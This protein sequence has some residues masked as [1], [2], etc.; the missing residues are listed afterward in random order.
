MPLTRVPDKA[1]PPEPSEPSAASPG[2]HAL[3]LEGVSKSFGDIRANED[4]TLRVRRGAI[5][6]IV[7]ENGAGKT[8]LMRIAYGFYQADAG[9][10]FVDD[11]PVDLTSPRVA[12]GSGIAMVHQ[13]SLLVDSLT[14]T[15]NILLAT[16]EPILSFAPAQARIREIGERY[17]LAVDPTRKVGQ[18]SVAAKQRVEILKALYFDARIIILDEPTAVLTPQ[19]ARGLFAHLRSFAKQGKTI[20]I[21]THKLPEVMA[22]TTEVSVMRGGRLVYEA[23]TAETTEGDIARA[24]VGRAVALRMHR[25]RTIEAEAADSTISPETVLEVRGLTVADDRAVPR[26]RSVDLDVRAGEIVGIAAVEGNGQS[27]LVE[28]VTGLRRPTEGTIRILGHDVTGSDPRRRRERGLR[29]IPEDRLQ[30][31]VNPTASVRENLICGRHYRP[32]LAGR[33][34]MRTEQVQRYAA[35]LMERF[36]ILA[37]DT[38]TRVGNLSGGNMQKVVI[39]RELEE[40]ARL[41]VAAQPT[42]GVDIGATESIRNELL[43][44]RGEGAAIL[45]VSSELSEI[46]DLA[47]R[48]VVLFSGS[49]A[50]RLS[51]REIQEEKLGLLMMGGASHSEMADA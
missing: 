5:H 22:V 49:V 12:L 32:P 34:R 14:V 9:H 31:G 42:Q 48:V 7:G 4:V 17:G 18:L 25:D 44:M 40:G 1:G 29:H 27:E 24:M 35:G 30:S 39:A 19:E 6:G 10:I 47:D 45:L 51:G 28:A 16:D 21:I 20:L 2:E 15:E 41:I 43:R 46:V 33:W 13:H 26:L 36:A 23:R 38:S 3:R 37:P 50:G 11:G 8:T